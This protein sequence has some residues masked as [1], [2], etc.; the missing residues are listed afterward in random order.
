VT[1]LATGSTAEQS[2]PSRATAAGHLTNMR[3]IAGHLV[4]Q[5]WALL[6]LLLLGAVLRLLVLIGYNPGFWY[7]GDS[8]TYLGLAYKHHP[9]VI[10]PY[11]YSFFLSLLLHL[12]SVRKIIAIQHVLGLALAVLGYAFLQRRGVSRLVSSLAAAPLLLDARTVAVEHFLLAETLFTVLV[13]VAMVALCWGQTPGWLGTLIAAGAFSWA[14]LTRTIGLVALAV[15]LLYLILRR[16][17]WR[18]TLA[19]VAIVAV[20]LGGYLVWYHSYQGQYTFSAYGGRFL[21]SRTTS[22]VDCRKLDLTPVE[23]PLCPSEPLGARLPPDVYLWTKAPYSLQRGEPY[24]AAYDSF[25][26][27]AIATQPGDY[28]ITIAKDLWLIFQS[29]TPLPAINPGYPTDRAACLDTTWSFTAPGDKGVCQPYLAP[30]NPRTG[31]Y[32]GRVGDKLH[33]PLMAPLHAYGAIAT[34]PTIL[35][36]L[37]FLLAIGLAFL[38]R[39]SSSWREHLDPLAWTGLAFGMIVGSIATSAVDARYA[40]P[41]LPLAVVGAAL[42]WQRFR[43]AGRTAAG[44]TSEGRPAPAR[45]PGRRD[46]RPRINEIRTGN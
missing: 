4:R 34:V 8:G 6:L 17:S 29:G 42:A 35:I 20:A 37:C 40:V 45:W 12:N 46:R 14:A 39:R 25:A 5:H 33:D 1:A 43:A 36:A 24:N 19:F 23:R 32:T 13:V 27:K 22:F 10:R 2:S 18:K 30:A 15:P 44:P 9:D 41:S 3:R 7:Q 16:V 21:W 26:R 11:G 38:R 31:R 28:A